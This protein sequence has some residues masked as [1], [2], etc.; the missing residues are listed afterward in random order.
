MLLPL[1]PARISSLCRAFS[2][3]VSNFDRTALQ[4]TDILDLSFLKTPTF[5][6]A[7]LGSEINKAVIPLAYYKRFEASRYYDIAFP[8]KTF[9]FLYYDEV[10]PCHPICG[11][12]RF[13]VTSEPS[14]DSFCTGKDL[15]K[16]N[17]RVWRLPIH[18]IAQSEKYAPLADHLVQ[19]GLVPASLVEHLRN[20]KS[21][22]IQHDTPAIWDLGQSF[23][24]ELSSHTW[25]LAVG[26]GK[27]IRRL[28]GRNPFSDGRRSSSQYHYPYKGTMSICE[29]LHADKK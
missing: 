25:R 26:R 24:F 13:R 20:I 3:V 27:N 8:P 19:V 21:L 2:R 7:S 23:D 1:R 11:E 22:N 16:P 5:H 9:G 17:G 10:H 6:V 29:L 28:V 18:R 12:P 4:A 14:P 15:L